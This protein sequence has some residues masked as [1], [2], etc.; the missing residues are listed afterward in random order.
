MVDD[1]ITEVL[2]YHKG[3]PLGG[4]DWTRRFLAIVAATNELCAATAILDGD[5]VVYDACGVVFRDPHLGSSA[6]TISAMVR[7]VA[8]PRDCDPC[9]GRGKPENATSAKSSSARS[10]N[11]WTELAAAGGRACLPSG[12]NSVDASRPVLE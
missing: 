3:D 1:E 10:D 11:G 2:A 9:P 6:T 12:P 7:W 4:H 5:A 8:S